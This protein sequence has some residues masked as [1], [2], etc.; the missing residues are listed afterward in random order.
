VDTPPI[1]PETIE[2]PGVFG[3]GSFY[4]PSGTDLLKE[5][6]RTQNIDLAQRFLFSRDAVNFATGTPSI[7]DFTTTNQVTLAGVFDDNSAPLFFL[8]ASLG[9]LT[10][11]DLTD[12][13]FPSKNPDLALPADTKAP[14]YGWQNYD[15]VGAGGAAI[16]L[17]DE[18]RPYTTRDGE[19]SDVT[20]LA[21]TMFEPPANFIEQYFPTQLLK[22]LQNAGKGDRSGD[23][24]HIRYDG[25][26]Q[27]PAVVVRAGDSQSNDAPDTGPAF[28]GTPP[29][30]KKRSRLL[31][32]PGYNHL[33]VL[34]A[35][36]RQNDG[37]PEPTA[38]ALADFAISVVSHQR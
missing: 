35:A 36:R 11:G 33:D 20:Q 8:R 3:V 18:G 32:V 17:N 27:R 19:A 24:S 29:N 15:E 21:R 26:A 34:T 16:P 31:T 1:V 5:L 13:N 38:K 2:L 14:L 22:D 7:R 10:G 9:F 6:P 25:P 28:R 12:K 30:K 37:R 23:L 4:D